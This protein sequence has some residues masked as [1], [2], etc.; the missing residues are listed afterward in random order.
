M[1]FSYNWLK[2]YI[3]I[4]ISAK[5]L[6]EKLTMA[7]LETL[8]LENSGEEILETEI[9]PNRPDCL[10]IM[11]IVREIGAVLKQNNFFRVMQ[12]VVK[13]GEKKISDFISVKIENKKL[14]P[15]YTARI[16]QN[17]KISDSPDWLKQRLKIA[18]FQ[19]I[20]NVV[21][22]TNYVLM[23]LGHPL[24]CF[25]LNKIL[26]KEILIKCT[27]NTTF[28]ALNN[29]EYNLDN[30]VLVIADSQKN[31]ALAGII[32]GKNAEVDTNTKNILLES[33]YFE[34]QNIRITSKKLNIQTESSYRFERGMNRNQLLYSLNRA[35]NLIVELAG[36]EIANGY[37]DEHEQE[38]QKKEIILQ[39]WKIKKLLGTSFSNEEIQEILNYLEFKTE[40]QNDSFIIK[41]PSF[42]VDI[43]QDVDIIEEI[44][45]IIGYDKIKVSMPKGEIIPYKTSILEKIE[46][47]IREFL[48]SCGLYEVITYSF[49]SENDLNKICL[50]SENVIKIQ[51]P[52]SIEQS[53]MRTTLIP[54]IL[55]VIAWNYKHG[56][57]D[58]KIFEIGNVYLP[59]VNNVLAYEKQML[60]GAFIGNKKTGSWKEK[61]EKIDFFD[62][63][64]IVEKILNILGI[65]NFKIIE[66]IHSTFHQSAGIEIDGKIL[67]NFGVIKENILKNY[68]L[69]KVILF[70]LEL[71]TIV[72]YINLNKKYKL[73]PKY[74]SISYDISF[75]LENSVS[76]EEIFTAMSEIN[77]DII[78][79]IKLIDL[80]QGKH[81]PD[82][83]KNL[84][85]SITYRSR[86]KT[87]TEDEVQLV[88]NSVKQKLIEKFNAQIR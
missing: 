6:A 81:I 21:D 1:R 80:Y 4:K 65:E 2:E 38:I 17:V 62:V 42:R 69:P 76:Y 43:T 24:H 47:I 88:H 48:I 5:K 61:E 84:A 41:I 56:I 13:E 3:D 55:Q 39:K 86:E 49:F 34:P 68:K 64:G 29:N 75:Y 9:T 77:K 18:G 57:K 53:I 36:G 70:E 32:G 79:E 63:K 10:G 15:R 74:P 16:I 7:G 59:K 28:F 71:D 27:S 66:I 19:S 11:G 33:A 35:T 31:L 82:G 23:E 51:N 22:V 14:C 54:N 60:V 44:A 67:G 26:G 45:R 73:I 52:L 25:D 58:I 72:P 87:L 40:E 83:Y 20:N 30:N 50:S 12:I 46:K 8:V 78:E 37:I 85:F